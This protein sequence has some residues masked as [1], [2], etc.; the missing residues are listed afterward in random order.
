[1]DSK[2]FPSTRSHS[3][4][5]NLSKGSSAAT[6]VTQ[7]SGL[8]KLK[9]LADSLDPTE[10]DDKTKNSMELFRLKLKDFFHHHFI[11]GLYQLILLFL[12]VISVFQYIYGTYVDNYDSARMN[13]VG[14]IMAKIELAFAGIFGFDWCL[15][16]FLADDR[17]AYL[18]SFFSMIDLLTVIP[19]FAV[20]QHECPQ[21]RKGMSGEDVIYYILCGMVTTRILRAL[22]VR[23]RFLFIEDE[24]QR[25]LANMGLNIAVMILYSKFGQ[26]HIFLL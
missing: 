4:S 8:D 7:N 22:R 9:K 5:N 18:T 13:L 14:L 21:F 26:L 1:M 23:S 10:Y 12:S 3:S 6:L 24:V 20:F 15:N 2:I 19:T 25:A 17:S 11:G 16:L